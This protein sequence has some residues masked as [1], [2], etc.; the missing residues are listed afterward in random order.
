MNTITLSEIAKEFKTQVKSID[1][2]TMNSDV[3]GDTGYNP[4][5][6]GLFLGSKIGAVS[7]PNMIK[8]GVVIFKKLTQSPVTNSNFNSYKRVV[9]NDYRSQVD[10]LLIDILKEKKDIV[11]NRFNFY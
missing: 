10:L 5:L 6:V 1:G 8:N 2:L 9:E 7:E 3:F 4:E 11:D